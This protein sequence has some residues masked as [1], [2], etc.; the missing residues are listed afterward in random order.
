MDISGNALG[1]LIQFLVG[2]TLVLIDHRDSVGC[3]RHLLTEHGND[4]RALVQLL[5][6][7]VE[8]IQQ[9]ALALGADV[10]VTQKGLA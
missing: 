7:L 2:K 8:T 9:S 3:F 5:V 10:D 4:S 1:N 6:G